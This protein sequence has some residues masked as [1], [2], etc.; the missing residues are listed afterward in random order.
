MSE[1]TA[2]CGKHSFTTNTCQICTQCKNCTGYGS[3]CVNCRGKDRS[4]DSGSACG[5]GPGAGGCTKCGICRSCAFENAGLSVGAVNVPLGMQP[6]QGAG[7][8]AMPGIGYGQPGFGFPQQMQPMQG[9]GFPQMQYQMPGFG[10]PQQIQPMQGFGFPQMQYQMPGFGFPQQIQPMQGFGFPQIQ[11][12]MPGVGL[13]QQPN[14]GNCT[15]VFVP[16]L[17]YCWMP[18]NMM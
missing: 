12:Q 8:P 2:G 3:A 10:F 1:A 4:P 7:N 18:S 17:G 11:Y 13:S 15:M 14:G 9:F 6:V 5:C 16:G